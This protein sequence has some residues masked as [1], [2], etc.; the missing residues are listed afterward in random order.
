MIEV[1]M[2][3][4]IVALIAVGTL[5]GFDSASR[6][7]GNER[8]HNQATLLAAQDEDRLRGL[9]ATELEQLGVASRSVTENGTTFTIKSSVQFVSASTEELT[10]ETSAGGANYLQTTSTVSWPGIGKHEAVKQSSII[11]VPT[12]LMLWVKVLNQNRE[13]VSG[14]KVTVMNS[15]RELTKAEETTPANG[16]V[17]FGS[18]PE[19]KVDVIASD[20]GYVNENLESVSEPTTAP[21]KEVSLSATSLT[22]PIEFFIAPAGSIVAEF[23]SNGTKVNGDTVFATHSGVTKGGGSAG[24]YVGSATVSG[25]FPFATPGSTPNNPYQVYAGD[26][27]KNSA[28]LVATTPKV[29]NPPAQVEP[30]G[31]TRV[32]VEVPAINVTVYEGTSESNK[33]ALDSKAEVKLT[34]GECSSAQ[35]TLK[36]TSSGNLE[37]KYQPYAKKLTLCVSQ[38]IGTQRYKYTTEFAAVAKAGITLPNIFMTATANKATSGC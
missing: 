9:N 33:G 6:A 13:G 20:T 18:L 32:S 11:D 8:A 26:C 27:E 34:N 15:K 1:I 3:A 10:C 24:T 29:K 2:S 21:A 30:A 7:T 17:I 25:L 23:E 12:S 35:R 14:A 36:L 37:Q 4:L 38:V 5:T 19:N 31:V 16:C 22:G 28:E